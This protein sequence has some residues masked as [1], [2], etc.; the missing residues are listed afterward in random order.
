MLCFNGDNV[1]NGNI[2]ACEVRLIWLRATTPISRLAVRLMTI[3]MTAQPSLDSNEPAALKGSNKLAGGARELF[4][5]EN[6]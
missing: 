5:A 1:R 6:N 2:T 4:P 3:S